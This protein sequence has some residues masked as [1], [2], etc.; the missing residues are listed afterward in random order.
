[1]SGLEWLRRRFG[2]LAGGFGRRAAASGDRVDAA[3]VFTGFFRRNK[4]GGR[5]SVSGTGSDAEQTRAIVQAL[6]PLLQRLGVR[7]V[8]DVPCGDFAWMKQ[9]DLSG[10]DY[11]GADIVAPLI[12]HNRRRYARPGV[13]FR[14]L[15]LTRDR[16]PAAD[17]VLCRDCLVHLSFAQA[18]QALA[19]IA[20]SGARYL[21]TTTFAGRSG[22][23]DIPTGKWRTLNLQQPPFD[24]PPP[25]ELINEQ[26]TEKNGRF[27]D[28][29][30]GLWA[31]DALRQK[32]ARGP[33]D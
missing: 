3:Q 26:C 18:Q 25:L 31:L 24:L 32:W 11:T 12:E 1:M 33:R 28:K 6:P 21:L 20:A 27:A 22:N 13:Q 23:V 29:S 7:S 5:Q 10:I 30:L 4:W 15:D 14:V 2:G 8:L 19:N 9:V 17:L 16:L